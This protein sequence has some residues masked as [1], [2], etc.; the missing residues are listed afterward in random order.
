M[1]KH[2]V[3]INT[4]ELS[5]TSPA[6]FIMLQY[7]KVISLTLTDYIRKMARLLNIIVHNCRALD[8]NI[9]KKSFDL[10]QLG[11]LHVLPN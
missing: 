4:L 2:S 7:A 6:A 1:A 3:R 9:F 5:K 8:C 10:T 11:T